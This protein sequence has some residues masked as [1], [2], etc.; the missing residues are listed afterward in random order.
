MIILWTMKFLKVLVNSLVGSLFFALLLGLLFA[1]LN[2]NTTITIPLLTGLTLRLAVV[3]G[4]FILVVSVFAFFVIQFFSGRRIPLALVS[5][6]FLLVSLPLL[7][8]TFLVIFR[9]N[10]AYFAS[11]FDSR[12]SPQVQAQGIVLFSLA[13]LGLAVFFIFRRYRSKAFFYPAYFLLLAMSLAILIGRRGQYSPASPS[14]KSSPLFGKKVERRITLMGLPGLSFDLLI[15]LIAEGKLP[16]FSWLIDNGSSGRLESFTP[17]EPV[18]LEASLF[19]GKYPG[20]HRQLSLSRYRLL[21]MKEPLEMVPRFILFKQLA[22]VGWLEISPAQPVPATSDFWQILEANRV[23]FIKKAWMVSPEATGQPPSLRAE[24]L[25][26]E[27]L[28][29]P[30]EP[31][32]AYL[33]LAREAFFHDW[34]TEEKAGDERSAL[35]PQ[36]SYLQLQGLNVVLTYFYKFRFPEQFGSLDQA[37]VGRY[38]PVIDRYYNFYDQVIGKSLTGLKEDEL[39]VVFSPHGIESLPLWKRAIESLLGNPMVSAHHEFAPD[40]VIFFYGKNVA[41]GK[42]FEGMRLVDITPTLLYYLGL[43]VGRDMD[44]TVRADAFQREF[45][46]DSPVVYI[47]SYDEFKI[48]PPDK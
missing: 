42:N 41:R 16:N 11:F 40:G 27:I 22:R 43:P 48:V 39:L 2:I 9:A 3:Y 6:S 46:A 44:G 7:T 47:S 45:T 38:G 31:E 20:K 33:A 17:C 14:T 1:D 10:V 5:P 4:P 29:G 28:E 26:S 12:L 35:Q 37:L 18:T 32:D 25:W 30:V 8:L 24:K 21:R 15:P 34:A 19:S 13:I 23:P 36:V